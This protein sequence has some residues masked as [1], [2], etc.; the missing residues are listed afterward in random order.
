MKSLKQRK[1]EERIK[2]LKTDAL[3]QAQ[4]NALKEKQND[5]YRKTLHKE[6]IEI[7]KGEYKT[8]KTKT[9]TYK[10]KFLPI[11]IGLA[12]A[13]I[14][15]SVVLVWNLMSK[16]DYDLTVLIFIRNSEMETKSG[17]DGEISE[18]FLQ[19]TDDFNKD[20]KTNVNAFYIPIMGENENTD[21][22]NPS[23]YIADSG[24]LSIQLDRYENL[25]II[26]DGKADNYVVPEYD[27]Y[28]LSY[29]FPDSDIIKDRKF[30]LKDS[31]LKEKIG[32]GYHF[33]DDA[34]IGLRLA[35][36]DNEEDIKNFQTQL[37]VVK[38]IIND[39]K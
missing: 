28:D 14:A 13:F 12:V 38:K 36:T 23:Q 30:Y 24:N 16:E 39:L 1:K 5:E 20:G 10:H 2:K 33:A 11:E 17:D 19:F 26:A 35:P 31:K 29:E 22:V 4:Q 27:L 32:Y 15:I 25:I 34:Y 18:Y 9:K 37:E 21:G 7:K 8:E 3:K 6:K